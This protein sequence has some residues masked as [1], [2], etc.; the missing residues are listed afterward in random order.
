MV[1]VYAFDE[2]GD[3]K[4]HII[5]SVNASSQRLEQAAIVDIYLSIKW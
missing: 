3:C 2:N 1:P 4:R 5:G